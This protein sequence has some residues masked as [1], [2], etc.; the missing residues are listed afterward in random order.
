MSS[1]FWKRLLGALWILGF[2]YALCAW[3]QSGIRLSETP[4]L[5]E[6]MLLQFGFYRAALCYIILYALR[7]LIFFP[8]TLLTIASG[9]L[10]G[11]WLGILFTII[12]ENASANFA[13]LLARWFGRG[14]VEKHESGQLQRWE[15]RLSNNG[16]LTVLIM[17]LVLLPFDAVN[18]GCGLTAM[19]Q[20]D[21]AIGTFIGILPALISFVLLGGIGASGVQDRLL[22]LIISIFFL[23][24]GLLVAKWLRGHEAAQA[25]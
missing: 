7:P 1:H 17:R 19:R 22:L 18:Y 8:A 4:Q 23:L 15:E 16:L 5:L 21:F 11:P 3:W 25:A 9:L 13:F 12:G 24:L 14:W 6:N 20:R 2:L 10:F